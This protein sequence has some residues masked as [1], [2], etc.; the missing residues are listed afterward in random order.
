MRGPEGLRTTQGLGSTP[1]RLGQALGGE[2]SPLR[3]W[4][5]EV[6]TTGAG[7]SLQ[8]PISV[9]GWK[10]LE[11][12]GTLTGFFRSERKVLRGI[13]GSETHVEGNSHQGDPSPR[14]NS[15]IRESASRE[16]CAAEHSDQEVNSPPVLTGRPSLPRTW[17]QARGPLS[18]A[19]VQACWGVRRATPEKQ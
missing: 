15:I 2:D 13:A 11:K 10:L 14:P 1:G 19:C 17:F 6:C 7:V 5:L 3:R 18:P 9:H 12:L 16:V 4:C 8:I